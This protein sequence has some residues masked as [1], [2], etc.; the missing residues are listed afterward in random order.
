[1]AR[2]KKAILI[3]RQAAGRTIRLLR[4]D[5]KAQKY[6]MELKNGIHITNQGAVKVNPYGDPIPLRKTQRAWRSGYLAARQDSADV[7][8]AKN[9]LAKLK[10]NKQKRRERRLAA[11]AKKKA[12]A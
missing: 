8:L 10:E 7:Y 12:S 6:A 5:E 3:N 9:N 11:R 4:P 1:M 2:D